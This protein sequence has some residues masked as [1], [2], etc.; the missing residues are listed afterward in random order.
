MAIAPMRSILTLGIGM[1]LESFA[2]IG[3][4]NAMHGLYFNTCSLGQF[5]RISVTGTISDGICLAGEN[6][7]LC[8][9]A[10][11]SYTLAMSAL[12]GRVTLDEN[13]IVSIAGTADLSHGNATASFSG[14]PNLT[15]LEIST[16]P[17]APSEVWFWSGT[18][19]WRGIVSSV[20]A[21][22][23]TFTTVAPFSVTSASFFI[24]NGWHAINDTNSFIECGG[25]GLGRVFGTTA[26][27][28]SLSNGL[29]NK[30]S[31]NAT[32]NTS[33]GSNIITFSGAVDLWT[34]GV[35][36]HDLMYLGSGEQRRLVQIAD[37]TSPTSLT[38]SSALDFTASN[39]DWATGAGD[40]YRECFSADNNINSFAG[41]SLIRCAAGAGLRLGGQTGAKVDG[42]QIDYCGMTGIAVAP[43]I[44]INTLLL[45]TYTESCGPQDGSGWNF[46]VSGAQGL[47]IQSP[48][49][50]ATAVT[51]VKVLSGSG[52]FVGRDGIEPIGVYRNRLRSSALESPVMSGLLTQESRLLSEDGPP[53]YAFS[54][55]ASWVP[56]CPVSV[57][58][59][60]GGVGTNTPM[61]GTPAIAPAEVTNRVFF[62]SVYAANPRTITLQDDSVLS[63]SGFHLRTPTLT[64]RAGDWVCL[65]G[66]PFGCVELGRNGP[67]TKRALNLDGTAWFS[68]EEADIGVKTTAA[69]SDGENARAHVW[70][71]HSTLS[72][73]GSRLGAWLN[74][75]VE[76]AY[77]LSRGSAV[78]GRVSV[79]DSME[80]YNVADGL[81][82]DSSSANLGLFN[83][84]S[85]A[86]LFLNLGTG[87]AGCTGGFT[88]GARVSGTEIESTSAG[89]GLVVKSPNGTRWRIE[90]DDT[91]TL[92][93]LPA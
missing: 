41:T 20:S 71:T 68:T 7:G 33:A 9:S 15:T 22:T 76:K 25:G 89:G 93:V 86:G 30:T 62:L 57:L 91:G 80:L 49:S 32:A 19:R 82:L 67:E 47:V 46:F 63:G 60:W 90:V 39:L 43:N 45:H 77:L 73:A 92:S 23:I 53:G 59:A 38:I 13:K 34:L 5:S 2:L 31:V 10:G 78:F 79:G 42:L 56:P 11:A 40:F 51:D 50:P 85:A 6:D 55:T 72:V 44:A 61:M 29:P 35:R 54:M 4:G 87:D 52:Y 28:S 70:D 66:T 17:N 21:T 14:A 18:Q 69:L 84:N 24:K 58:Y 8:Y 48:I 65:L 83:A 64:L 81:K 74:A 37:V 75:G 88:S 36:V 12:S 16:N 26:F 3:N 27:L 1:H